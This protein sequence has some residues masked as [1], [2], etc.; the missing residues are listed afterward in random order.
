MSFLPL[1]KCLLPCERKNLLR[2][3]SCEMKVFII[4][5]STN[6]KTRILSVNVS[7]CVQTH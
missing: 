7:V 3:F 2:I 4:I 1:Q 6:E 5:I